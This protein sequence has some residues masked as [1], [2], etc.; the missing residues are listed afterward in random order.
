MDN[1]LFYRLGCAAL[2]S[3]VAACGPEDTVNKVEC[4]ANLLPGELVITELMADPAG[5]DAGGEWFE[6]YNTTAAIIP[7]EGTVLITSAADRS[8]EQSHVM[9]NIRILPGQYLVVGNM[10]P[11]ALP[12]FADY[13]YGDDLE[14][15]E[16]GGRV[17]IKCN[18][19]TVDEV[20]YD[21][22]T[23]GVSRALSSTVV[24]N[25]QDNDNPANWCQAI[26][27]YGAGN[28]GTPGLANDC[29]TESG[30]GKC[31]DGGVSR[32]L[33]PPAIGDLVITEIMVDPSAV[34]DT[35]GEWFEVYVS[36]DVDLNGLTIG[37][38]PAAGPDR[39]LDAPTCLRAT[40]GSYLVFAR[41]DD[42]A[43][44]GGLPRV[45]HLFGFN[46]VNSGGAL[47]V[48]VGTTVLDSI[49]WSSSQAGTSRNLDPDY[50]DIL[51]NDNIDYWCPGV[52]VY[53]DGDRGTPGAAN[54]Q[55]QI[56]IPGSCN[57][58]GTLRA[59]VS[60][61]PGQVKITEYMANPD[62]VDDANGEWFEVRFDAAVDLN[63][64]ELLGNGT[65][66]SRIEAVECLRVQAG[67]YAVFARKADPGQNGGLPPVDGVF[68]F[69]L[70]NS[71]GNISVSVGGVG[72]DAVSY[73]A[74][75]AGAS[76]SLDE[77]TGETWCYNTVDPYG[78]GDNHGTPG[79]AN[80]ACP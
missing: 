51:L 72:L 49:A 57:D 80:P 6:I 46:L 66:P 23:E 79:V 59:I 11:D 78:P 43:M 75:R 45:D 26:S 74:T 3:A 14:L 33:V 1:C 10:Q 65:T 19:I 68:N 37:R 35:L 48:G 17:A 56:V 5:D 28:L 24:P 52:D 7:L 9:G 64:L 69:A 13:G 41:N 58:D 62:V 27:E 30:D 32:P 15:R 50:F 2:L 22:S 38:D 42:P 73:G 4:V 55:C 29:T 60:P 67:T 12:D 47:F 71:N 40:A 63:E 39:V 8:E 31:G 53:G 34:G 77:G 21:S 76:T 70:V 54:Q 18:V 36:R 20:T 25:H 61:E 44:N 16:A